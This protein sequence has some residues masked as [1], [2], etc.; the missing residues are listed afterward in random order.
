MP[1]GTISGVGAAPRQFFQDLRLTN[2][3]RLWW[4]CSGANGPRAHHGG[5][6]E[7]LVAAARLWARQPG[8]FHVGTTAVGSGGWQKQQ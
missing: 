8:S 2:L 6:Q 7:V 5:R 1:C 4:C 3:C